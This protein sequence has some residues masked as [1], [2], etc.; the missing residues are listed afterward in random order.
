MSPI[1]GQ[2]NGQKEP[3]S[4]KHE[5]GQLLNSPVV[6]L[7]KGQNKVQVKNCSLEEYP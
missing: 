7:L 1:H 3:K 2:D 6:Y 5:I 4:L